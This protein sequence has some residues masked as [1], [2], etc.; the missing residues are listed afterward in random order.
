MVCVRGSSV[1]GSGIIQ[2]RI[3]HP[4]LN[5][6]HQGRGNDPSDSLRTLP[7]RPSPPFRTMAGTFNPE[8]LTLNPEPPPGRRPYGPEAEPINPKPMNLEPLNP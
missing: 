5:P 3:D 6:S 1:Q 8:P 2:R 4:P 7:A